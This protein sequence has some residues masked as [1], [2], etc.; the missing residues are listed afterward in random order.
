M[1]WALSAACAALSLAAPVNAAAGAESLSD[2]DF[3]VAVVETSLVFAMFFL[4]F[5]SDGGD[6]SDGYQ[7]RPLYSCVLCHYQPYQLPRPEYGTNT[8]YQMI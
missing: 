6:G 2:F 8:P 5:W 7:V 3:V 1:Y 4:A